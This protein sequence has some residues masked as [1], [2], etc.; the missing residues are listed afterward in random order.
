MVAF[1]IV[2]PEPAWVKPPAPVMAALLKS[3]PWVAAL[4]RFTAKVAPEPTLMA[5]LALSVPVVLPSP[6]CNMP[7]LTVVAPV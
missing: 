7:E 3:V 2:V 4:D 5:L 6:S 1:R